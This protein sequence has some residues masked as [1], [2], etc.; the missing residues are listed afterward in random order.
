MPP[1]VKRYSGSDFR[2]WPN[3][4]TSRPVSGSHTL[5]VESWL[6]EASQRLLLTSL[7]SE[8]IPIRDE[9]VTEALG[10]WKVQRVPLE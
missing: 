1:R 3:I 6:P 7:V 10:Y 2:G 5:I 4:R 9:T 8:I